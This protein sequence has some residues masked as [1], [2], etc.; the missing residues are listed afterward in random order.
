MTKVELDKRVA[1][2]KVETKEALEIVL[3]ELN[4]GQRKK[5][6]NN[7]RVKPLLDRYDVTVE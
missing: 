2:A 1:D 5:I 3:A 7:E 4:H 6:V